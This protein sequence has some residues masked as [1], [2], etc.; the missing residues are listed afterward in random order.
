MA[1]LK[2]LFFLIVFV[3]CLYI[4]IS[5]GKMMADDPLLMTE[6]QNPFIASQVEEKFLI[7]GVD[8]FT[9]PLA[10]LESVW[11]VTLRADS[12]QIE[13]LPLYPVS[14]APHLK[15]Y[16]TRHDPILVPTDD[17]DVLR[18]IEVIR[19]QEVDWSGMI[20]LDLIGLNMVVEIAGERH[21]PDSNHH[22][23]KNNDLPKV[24]ETPDIALQKQK[25]IITFLCGNSKPFS[26]HENIKYLIEFIPDHFK[27]TLSI[28]DLWQQWQL[29]SNI[30]FNLTCQYSW[31]ETP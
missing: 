23:G 10:R 5:I 16:L 29:F 20:M 6:T 31:E 17:F 9:Q 11:L 25:N 19:K 14:N 18:G 3:L 27:S 26:L 8:D 12:S 30:N 22:D 24:W 7:A 4:G 28:E 21:N 1:R 2:N 15:T 13:L